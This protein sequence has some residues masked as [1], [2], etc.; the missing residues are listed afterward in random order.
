MPQYSLTLD[1]AQDLDEDTAARYVDRS[2][3]LATIARTARNHGMTARVVPQM[4]A[5]VPTGDGHVLVTSPDGGILATRS[6][7]RLLAWLGY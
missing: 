7:V 3:T 1:G 2:R 4:R 5:G 6:V